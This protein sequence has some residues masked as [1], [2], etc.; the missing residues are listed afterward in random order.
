MPANSA[1]TSHCHLTAVQA[2]VLHQS[3]TLVN[4]ALDTLS[5]NGFVG[6]H[7]AIVNSL[8]L[9]R[10]LFSALTL[11]ELNKIKLLMLCFKKDINVMHIATILL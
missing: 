8:Y 1:F 2:Y 3:T 5:F 11:L 9:K 6:W 7:F 10:N 4:F